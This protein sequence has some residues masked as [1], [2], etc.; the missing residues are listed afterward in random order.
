MLPRA[1]PPRTQME[2]MTSTVTR[3]H[4]TVSPEFV[5][6]LKEAK[7]GQSHVQPD[8][9]DEQVLTA[10]LK[11]LLEK[12]A[13]RKACVPARVKRDVVRRDG[14]RCQWPTHDGG[15]CGSTVRL[16]V[17]HALPRGKGGADAIDNCRLL[18]DLHNQ[19]AARSVYGDAHMDLFTRTPTAGEVGAPF[20]A[21]FSRSSASRSG[22]CP[23]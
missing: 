2:P 10:A 21:P 19:E 7:A 11:L 20:R 13:R 3:I 14:G 12:Q 17:D 8:A 5:T 22:A 4:L 6:L 15:I 1:A 16:E 18:C 9:T 23:P